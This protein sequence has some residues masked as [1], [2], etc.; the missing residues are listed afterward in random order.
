[1]DEEDI[2]CPDGKLIPA[3]SITFPPPPN[4]GLPA[5]TGRIFRPIFHKS[6]NLTTDKI[7]YSNE[8]NLRFLSSSLRMLN[9]FISVPA[10]LYGVYNLLLANS[11]SIQLKNLGGKWQ[12][13]TRK[14]MRCHGR[15][16]AIIPNQFSGGRLLYTLHCNGYSF[17]I[18]LFWE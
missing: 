16:P 3:P 12:Q 7:I 13:L 18:F 6:D 2:S 1:M 17:Y 15:K 11:L 9:N 4:Q 10:I 14:M 5:Q 8:E